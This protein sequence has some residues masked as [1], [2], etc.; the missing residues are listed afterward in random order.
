VG[1]TACCNP[2]DGNELQCLKCFI[3]PNQAEPP[4]VSPLRG[5]AC[6]G[7][8]LM[9]WSSG[10]GVVEPA[11]CLVKYKGFLVPFHLLKRKS[12]MLY[13]SVCMKGCK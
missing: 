7:K 9:L 10:G 13:Y 2:W 5:C 3:T 8:R 4:P 11:L 6:E 12:Y 1:Q